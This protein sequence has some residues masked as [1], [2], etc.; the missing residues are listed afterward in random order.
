MY[1]FVVNQPGI[2]GQLTPQE[3]P[4]ELLLQTIELDPVF[5]PGFD[6]IVAHYRALGR[7]EDAYEVLRDRLTPWLPWLARSSKVDAL[8]FVDYLRGWANR[9]GQSD[10]QV[11][12]S[13]VA[14]V[15]AAVQP[16]QRRTWFD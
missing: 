12:L 9:T 16:M 13:R 7:E 8:R 4:A 14:A 10:Y 3:D 1:A 2:A 15:V 5:V 6:A 11:E